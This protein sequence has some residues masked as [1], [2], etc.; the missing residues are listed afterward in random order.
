LHRIPLIL[1][2]IV[3]VSCGDALQNILMS[4]DE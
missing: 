1:T 2:R 4:S 3:C